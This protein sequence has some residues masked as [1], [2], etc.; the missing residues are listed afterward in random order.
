MTRRISKAELRSLRNEVDVAVILRH[1]E[2]PWKI[3]EG[4]FRFLCPLCS[5]FHTA[6]NP[7][8]NLARCFRC[9]KNFNPIDLVI[10]VLGKSF[11]DAVCYL[12]ELKNVPP[13]LP[14]HQEARE[15]DHR[16]A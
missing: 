3:R 2:I 9:G 15:K 7:R 12:R 8:T 4:Y 14:G 13:P 6:T 16:I 11:L 10:L 5:D 1:L